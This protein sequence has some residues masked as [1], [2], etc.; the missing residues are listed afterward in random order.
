LIHFYKRLINMAELL[1]VKEECGTDNIKEDDQVRIKQDTCGVLVVGV[2]DT[3]EEICRE[4]SSPQQVDESW[5]G[6]KAADVKTEMVIVKEEFGTE[7]IKEEYEQ[8]EDPLRT[9]QGGAR[10]ANIK[11]SSK[12]TKYH[13][14]ECD[15]TTNQARYLKQHKEA[16]HLG[17]R[18]P[19]DLCEYGATTASSL[20]VHK[21]KKPRRN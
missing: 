5:L 13:C 19:C 2:E 18:Y 11:K 14:T 9:K 8:E 17:I 7:D 10:G 6:N 12:K 16:K 20:K 15:F 4:A 1:T 3:K 21:K